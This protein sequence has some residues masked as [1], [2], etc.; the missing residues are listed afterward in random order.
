MRAFCAWMDLVIASTNPHKVQEFSEILAPFGVRVRGLSN[1]AA[2]VAEPEET[3][4][5][6]A[7]NARIKATTYA[8]ALGQIC[9]ADDSGL[10]VDGLGGA[11]GVLSA[12]YAGVSG[13]R[14]DRDRANNAKLLAELRQRPGALR[15]ARL[16]CALCLADAQGGVLFETRATLAGELVDEARGGHGFGYDTHLLLPAEGK[17]VAQLSA[18]ELSVLSH[19]AQASRALLQ[20][21]RARD[22]L[23]Q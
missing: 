5:T 19:R 8:H 3:S 12:R 22:W 10:E 21:L 20:W 7:G 13:R 14:E 9:L 6:F 18:A 23:P 15:S 11:P 4:D 1:W 16:V 2:T 17:T